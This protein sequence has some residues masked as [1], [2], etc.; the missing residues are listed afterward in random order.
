MAVA[1]QTSLIRVVQRAT[2]LAGGNLAGL[3]V[4]FALLLALA[5]R[6][7]PAAF[8]RFAVTTASLA[9]SNLLLDFGLNQV[10]VREGVRD[11]ERSGTLFGSVLR[12]KAALAIPAL[13]AVLVAWA[14]AEIPLTAG[15]MVAGFGALAGIGISTTTQAFLV[16]ADRLRPAG[17]VRFCEGSLPL[18]GATLVAW[19]SQDLTALLLGFALGAF[20]TGVVALMLVG[21]PRLDQPWLGGSAVRAILS[22]GSWFLA[23]GLITFGS[24]RATLL[25]AG[26]R[27][28]AIETGQFSLALRLVDPVLVVLS[29]IA[30][31]N[32]RD[33]VA[34]HRRTRA[35]LVKETL[36]WTGAGFLVSAA[37]FLAAP[38]V[39]PWALGPEYHAAVPVLQVLLLVVPLGMGAIPTSSH[40]DA[41]GDQDLHLLNGLYMVPLALALAWMFSG[42]LGAVGIAW[43]IVVSRLVGLVVGSSVLIAGMGRRGHL[44]T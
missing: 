30:L 36:L 7:E 28:P 21:G 16:A 15:L 13:G 29:A 24:W 19:F 27:L 22:E 43:A 18:F 9:L 1:L 31:V 26:N 44:A 10:M 17:L 20:C 11:P 4:G 3:A 32:Y 6:L 5:W 2:S 42:S 34:S 12:V 41:F 23:L 14:I 35:R 33:T 38:H 40:A 37:G 25:I 8:G 39:V